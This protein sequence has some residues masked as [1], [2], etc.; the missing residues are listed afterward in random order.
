MAVLPIYT[1][2]LGL[3]A[4]LGVM[5][6]AAGIEPKDGNPQFAVPQLVQQMFPSW[7]VGVAFAAIAMSALVP[8]AIMAIGAGNLVSRNLVREFSSKE[9]SQ[10]AETQ[11]SKIVSVLVKLGALVFVLSLDSQFALN[12]QLLGGIWMLQTLPAVIFGIFLKRFANKTGLIAG[13]IC[14]FT[15]GTVAA[16]GVESANTAH[17]GGST[18]IP[19]FLESPIYIAISGLIINLVVTAAVCV[20]SNLLRDG[21]VLGAPA[22]DDEDDPHHAA[23][24]ADGDADGAPERIPTP[25]S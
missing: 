20:V 23:P 13:W 5:A 25:V 19:F 2:L 15:Y 11:I 21:S 3:V 9:L 7:F 14:G 6:L 17:F 1:V 8:A 10:H 12:F 22:P 18:A 16:Y 24:A 4:L